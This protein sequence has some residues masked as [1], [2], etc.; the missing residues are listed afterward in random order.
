MET[1]QFLR[2][3]S[4]ASNSFSWLWN[5][6]YDH[7]GASKIFQ[8]GTETTLCSLLFH[9]YVLIKHLWRIISYFRI[10]SAY[11]RVWQNWL[12]FWRRKFDFHPG[13]HLSNVFIVRISEKYFGTSKKHIFES[14]WDFSLLLETHMITQYSQGKSFEARAHFWEPG[15]LYSICIILFE[16][17]KT[18]YHLWLLKNI[19]PKLLGAVP[20]G[21]SPQ[22]RQIYRWNEKKL[23][24]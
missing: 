23:G 8:T 13:I 6:H 1:K 16:E 20:N 2:E 10:I 5:A 3:I 14:N 11:G 21:F 9:D 18:G 24:F 19:F 22:I 17:K 15:F 4:G 7:I 12:T